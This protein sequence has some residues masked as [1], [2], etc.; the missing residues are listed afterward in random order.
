MTQTLTRA[1]QGIGVMLN[2]AAKRRKRWARLIAASPGKGI[3]ELIRSVN[4]QDTQAVQLREVPPGTPE[5]LFQIGGL[6]S[7]ELAD[8]TT[9]E[10][11]PRTD[12][13]CADESERLHVAG[14]YDPLP[15][16][17]EPN[18]SYNLG[19][20]LRINYRVT[21]QQPEST[22]LEFERPRPRLVYRNGYLYIRGGD[23]DLTSATRKNP[24]RKANLFG[25]GGERHEPGE[26]KFYTSATSPCGWN[27]T[28]YIWAKN[29]SQ[30]IAKLKSE[31]QKKGE[32][33]QGVE[34]DA[35]VDNDPR[36]PRARNGS[37][38]KTWYV[39]INAWGIT[40][41]VR[42]RTKAEAISK[43]KQM[44][45]DEGEDIKGARWSAIAEDDP[46]AQPID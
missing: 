35:E 25:F 15:S 14:Y 20:I 7:F 28:E 42:A 46:R 43:G 3:A 38:G 33:L 39:S 12:R 30:A 34:W 44:L 2:P 27:I 11:D 18:V 24:T 26:K 5:V 10:C 6:V 13:I 36:A 1:Q 45:R 40:R 37:S 31:L 21:K 32:N 19:P 16:E 4:K 17:L 22:P 41:A 23:Y 9:I 29:R 8:G